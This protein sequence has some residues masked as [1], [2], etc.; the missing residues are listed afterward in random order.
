MTVFRNFLK[1]VF[2]FKK[3]KHNKLISQQMSYLKY[4]WVCVFKLVMVTKVETKSSA[5]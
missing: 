2:L 4:I 3:K 5:F 1:L